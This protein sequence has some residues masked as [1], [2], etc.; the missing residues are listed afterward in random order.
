M[1]I[2][3]I[4]ALVLPATMFEI[5]TQSIVVLGYRAQSIVGV[6]LYVIINYAQSIIYA[7]IYAL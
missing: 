4:F 7:L 6:N 5:A 3:V 1:S 2:S